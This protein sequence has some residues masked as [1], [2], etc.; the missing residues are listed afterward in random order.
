MCGHVA[1]LMHRCTPKVNLLARV[2]NSMFGSSQSDLRSM[3]I[4]FIHSGL[5]YAAPVWFPLLSTT[6]LKKLATIET[7]CLRL[8]LG[9]PC[10]TPN[11]DLYLEAN[12]APLVTRLAFFTGFLAEKY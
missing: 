10:G 11:N 2:A 9:A 4:A 8:I 1:Q 3:Y 12:L 7:K 6:Q 5:E